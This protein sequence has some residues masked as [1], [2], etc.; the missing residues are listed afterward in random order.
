MGNEEKIK[1][2]SEF[3][4]SMNEV[5]AYTESIKGK[6]PDDIFD[7]ILFLLGLEENK[8]I[9]EEVIIAG[10][11][12]AIDGYIVDFVKYLDNAG[13]KPLASCSGLDEEHQE[14]KHPPTQG[15]LAI[16][17]KF[18]YI[19]YLFNHF[20]IKG[21]TIDKGECYFKDCISFTIKGTTDKEKKRLWDELFIFF[22]KNFKL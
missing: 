22:K 20:D 3:F 12:V 6:V 5:R 8:A 7:D 13:Y 9:T 17:Y 16:E 10:E 14:S 18:E 11:E 19:E 1:R 4:K 2:P 21:I 15:Y